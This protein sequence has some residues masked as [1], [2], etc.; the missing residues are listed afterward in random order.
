MCGHNNL[1]TW[2]ISYYYFVSFSWD[3]KLQPAG[4]ERARARDPGTAR[5]APAD[6]REGA[7]YV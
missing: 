2:F 6:G 5:A 1:T 7:N 3:G 4:C